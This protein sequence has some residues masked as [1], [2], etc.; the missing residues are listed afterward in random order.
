MQGASQ[1]P[2]Q[3]ENNCHPRGL[4]SV[5]THPTR[6]TCPP[7]APSHMLATPSPWP[8]AWTEAD[9]ERGG[10]WPAMQQRQGQTAGSAP[11]PKS[12]QANFPVK[13][14]PCLGRVRG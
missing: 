4:F 9:T 1:C 12:L 7:C 10:H 11:M 3:R 2:A 8:S 14:D 5:P 13:G 6:P